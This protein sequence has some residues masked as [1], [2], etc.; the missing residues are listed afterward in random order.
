MGT[1]FCYNIWSFIISS[2]NSS[3][4]INIKGVSCYS[5]QVPFNHTW[6]LESTSRWELVAR[7]TNQMIRGVG[8]SQPPGRGKGRETG[9]QFSMPNV[10]INLAYV[11]KAPYNPKGEGSESFQ[12]WWTRI[13]PHAGGWHTLSSSGTEVPM[14]R[15]LLDLALCTSSSDCSVSF[16]TNW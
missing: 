2:W 15:T 4:T 11:M 6:V 16:I 3:R 1:S 14:L 10:L 5:K 8:I 9:V 7:E 13:Y 12:A